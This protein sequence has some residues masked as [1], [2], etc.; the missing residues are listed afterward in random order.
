MTRAQGLLPT[1]R[2]VLGP[3]SALA[4]VLPGYEVR[5]GQLRMAEATERALAG[6]RCLFVEAGTGTGKTLAYLVPAVLSGRKVVVST[7]TRALQDQIYTKDLPLVREVLAQHGVHFR[8]T[9]MKG[10][11]NYVC[12]RRLAE[13][14][15]QPLPERGLGRIATW[16]AESETGDRAELADMSE[17]EPAWGLVAS[18]TDTRIG[19][20][21][22]YYEECFVT[23][24][25][26]E[27]EQADVLVVNHHL[28]CADLAL[29]R[30]G[31]GEA[32]AIPAYDAVIFDE[33]HQLEDIATAFFG[34]SVSSARIEALVRD[35]KRTLESKGEN[36]AR[37]RARPIF[38][39][40]QDASERFFSALPREA[41]GRRTLTAHELTSEVEGARLRLDA[42]L[43]GLEHVAEPGDRDPALQQLSRRAEEVRAALRDVADG[44]RNPEGS[45]RVS[46]VESRERSVAIGYSP[47][48]LGPELS[49]ALFSQGRAVLCTSATLATPARGGT[50][51][52]SFARARLGAPDDAEELFIPSPFDFPARAGFYVASDLPEPQDPAFE[53]AAAA[54]IAELV[55]I[56]GGGA[57]VLCTSTRSMRGLHA[58][59]KRALPAP[60]YLQGERPKGLLLSQFRAA[61]HAVLVAT[62]SFWE[63]VDVP[64]DALRMVIMDKIPFPVPTDPVVMARC[65]AIDRGGE[66]SF[67]R[68]Y[69]PQAAITLKQGF[70]RLIRSQRDA[71]VVALLDRR[72][73]TKG[74]GRALLAAIPPA[75]RLASVEEVQ[76]FWS[77]VFPRADP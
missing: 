20:G 57:F 17:D 50:Q 32:S 4:R 58:R 41:S 63:G 45:A 49:R 70:G 56:S 47:V 36:V 75:R 12:K 9:L 38:E 7:A 39:L 74:Y 11:S 71:G 35:A 29:R 43:E 1:V 52:F 61:R 3:D 69:V 26:R 44:A 10:L 65:A 40:I 51:D 48:D 14:Q 53:A 67:F 18:S 21:C 59:L 34:A 60:V 24:M 31:R 23:S 30:M 73:V 22:K 5:E 54:R 2:E 68:Y 55:A 8:A 19:A 37:S 27:A 64:G 33:A 28:F 77:E 62:M 66:S 6:D 13:A 42:C 76:S 72:A 16:A 15:M 25:R 46:W